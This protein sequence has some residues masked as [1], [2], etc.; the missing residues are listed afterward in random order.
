MH[1]FVFLLVSLELTLKVFRGGECNGLV[2]LPVN[3]DYR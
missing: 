2:S 1:L 3:K